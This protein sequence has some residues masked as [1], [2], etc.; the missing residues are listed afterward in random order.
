M[1]Y[2]RCKPAV[3]IIRHCSH[4]LGWSSKQGQERDVSVETTVRFHK[5]DVI[6]H[7]KVIMASKRCHSWRP[8]ANLRYDGDI[9]ASVYFGMGAQES[10]GLTNDLVLFTRRLSILRAVVTLLEDI[11]V[12]RYRGDVTQE[13][14]EQAR[15][16]A[17]SVEDS[18]ADA[19]STA[20]EVL[21]PAIPRESPSN[22]DFDEG[23][24][25]EEA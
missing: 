21:Q 7:G 20:S 10:T 16:M 14:L 18:Y 5:A 15:A 25:Y 24:D 8:E 3:R 19:H 2:V 17:L 6:Y 11:G 13:S 1:S 23:I 4:V 9:V 12:N 22:V